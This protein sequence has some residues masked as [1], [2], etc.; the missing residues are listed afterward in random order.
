MF[1]HPQFKVAMADFDR[2][3]K[4]EHGS[5]ESQNDFCIGL[6]LQIK[7]SESFLDDGFER[8]INAISQKVQVQVNKQDHSK[9]QLLD[10]NKPDIYMQFRNF[11]IKSQIYIDHFTTQPVPRVHVISQRW[12]VVVLQGWGRSSEIS[13]WLRNHT[14]LIWPHKNWHLRQVI[15]RVSLRV[16]HFRFHSLEITSFGSWSPICFPKHYVVQTHFVAQLYHGRLL[17]GQGHDSSD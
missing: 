17:G 13:G 14:T 6:L 1:C 4:I 2:V 7:F 3:L 15:F 9:L 16:H 11:Y 5:Q 8:Q 10:L 12:Q